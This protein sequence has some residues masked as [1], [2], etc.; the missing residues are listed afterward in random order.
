MI[1]YWFNNT[2]SDAKLIDGKACVL[3]NIPVQS[4]VLQIP[5]ECARC[6]LQKTIICYG[7]F[8]IPE[9]VMKPN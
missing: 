7:D 1:L 8:N 6:K 3:C 4:R 5:I 9:N 2:Y